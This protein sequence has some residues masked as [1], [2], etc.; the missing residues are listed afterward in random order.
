MLTYDEDTELEKSGKLALPKSE[1]TQDK[2]QS[3]I[4]EEM[5]DLLKPK[6]K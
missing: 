5:A 6:E 4:S 2:K 3:A 1:G